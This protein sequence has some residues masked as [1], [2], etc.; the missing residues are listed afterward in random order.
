MGKLKLLCLFCEIVAFAVFFAMSRKENE[1]CTCSFLIACK[2]ILK[3]TSAVTGCLHPSL[4]PARVCPPAEPRLIKL[5]S[6]GC[7]V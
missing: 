1:A 4:A 6:W 3:Q 2:L 5:M 7:G